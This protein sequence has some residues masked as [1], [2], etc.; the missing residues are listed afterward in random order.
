MQ[1]QQAAASCAH[2]DQLAEQLEELERE[3]N[4]ER[5]V[6]SL[7][8]GSRVRMMRRTHEALFNLA[9]L[10]ALVRPHIADLRACAEALA[11]HPAFQFTRLQV[12]KS[13]VELE[14]S[15]WVSV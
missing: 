13:A 5:A 10:R 15:C 1:H 4:H 7:V 14:A 8:A 9:E 6:M 12:L 2:C 3:L 11:P